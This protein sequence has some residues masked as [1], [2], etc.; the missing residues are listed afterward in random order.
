M[1]IQVKS[2]RRYLWIPICLMVT[3]VLAVGAR[4][5][6]E[7]LSTRP[8]RRET[9]QRKIQ[10][11]SRDIVT[12]MDSARREQWRE[13]AENQPKALLQACIIVKQESFKEVNE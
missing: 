1:N 11:W 2:L 12:N 10:E 8:L 5:I 4:D 7:E 6:A 9:T 3:T 13:L